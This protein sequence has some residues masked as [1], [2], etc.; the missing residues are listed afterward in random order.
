MYQ[1][2]QLLVKNH[3]NNLKIVLKLIYLNYQ[4]KVKNKIKILV[5]ININ[6]TI[7]INFIRKFKLEEII[8][9]FNMLLEKV[10]LVKYGVLL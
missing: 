4:E 8:F 7:I 5:N 10:D 3:L 6:I 9:N 2:I 1:V